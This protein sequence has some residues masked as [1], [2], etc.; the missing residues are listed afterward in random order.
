MF[1]DLFHVLESLEHDYR[2]E[3]GKRVHAHGCRRCE[4]ELRLR[5]ARGQILRLLSDLEF[6]FG[7]QS[8]KNKMPHQ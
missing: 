5:D 3:N 6:D 8:R 1:N 4:L 7:G 2:E